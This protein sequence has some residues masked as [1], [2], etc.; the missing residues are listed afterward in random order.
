MDKKLFNEK[1]DGILKVISYLQTKNNVKLAYEKTP[2]EFPGVI[3]CGGFMSDMTGLKAL[4]VEA[5]CRKR[6][7]AFVRFD[8]QGH[9]QSSGKFEDGSIGQWRNDA[10]AILD[11]LTEGPQI[12]VGS[13]MGGW[14]GLLL[15]L[16]RPERV[17]GF[18]G[19]A[20]AP[21]F[22]EDLV[23]EMATAEQKAQLLQVG[24][25]N[26]HTGYSDNSYVITRHLIEE[27]REHL[28]LRDTIPLT[29]PVRLLHGMQDTDVPWQRSLLL[30]EK[31]QSQDVNVLTI[32]DGNHRLARDQDLR[33]LMQ[34]MT[35]L[36]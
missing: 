3:F 26:E 7:Q 2:G 1:C 18:V 17:R 14:I 31:L 13:S 4:A 24:F 10:L 5:F 28:L 20:A 9:G 16:A 19:I 11:E 25:I 29:I 21:D 6:G 36:F 12:I 8:Y 32:K 34:V 33:L 22:T 35:S 15:A 27:G 23:W 30:A